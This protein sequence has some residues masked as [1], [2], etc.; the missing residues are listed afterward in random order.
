M[1]LVQIY[2]KIKAASN[3][4]TFIKNSVFGN[5]FQTDNYSLCLNK[6]KNKENIRIGDNCRIRCHLIA[7][8]SGKIQIG[9]NTYIGGPSKIGAVESITIGNDVIISVDVH[10]FDNNN[11]PT[12]PA[13][14][15]AMTQSADSEGPLWSWTESESK[16]VVI[17]D[18]VW[19][20]E[21]CTILKGVRIGKGSIV[22]CNSVVTKDVPP[23][24]IVAG[25][26][27]KV[28]KS[29]LEDRSDNEK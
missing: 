15:L 9:N 13:T 8:G 29:L 24:T 21:R 26:P 28:V 12:D 10:V 25:N 19:I 18:N 2:K 16:P 5:N 7:L 27:A 20:G 17:E 1:L 4:K 11:H 14:R 3:R 6:T 22:A 23:Y